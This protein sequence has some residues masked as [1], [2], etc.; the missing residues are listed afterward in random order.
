MR[1][2]RVVNLATRRFLGRR[3]AARSTRARASR[4]RILRLGASSRLCRSRYSRSW[5][6]RVPARAR[7]CSCSRARRASRPRERQRSRRAA[8]APELVHHVHGKSRVRVARTWREGAIHH[9]VE[10]NVEVVIES[11]MA[12]AYKTSS[13]EGM[14]ATDTTKNQCYV[15]ARRLRERCGRKCTPSRSPA[16]SSTSTPSSPPCTS[17]SSSNRGDASRS[18]AD[19][20]TTGSPPSTSAFSRSPPRSTRRDAP[21][22]SSGRTRRAA[23]QN[24]A[25]RVRGISQRRTHGVA[26]HAGSNP[27]DGVGRRVV[28]RARREPRRDR[29]RRAVT[30]NVARA[31]TELFYGPPRGAC[32][33]PACN[34]RCIRWERRWWNA[35]RRCDR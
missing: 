23:A 31:L 19:R 28:V 1:R 35:R 21:E 27:G 32:I 10:W 24:H 18:W 22:M 12:H 17:A 13:N 34:T 7:E 15:V 9:F 29:F 8:M 16:S 5:S 11:D 4:V 33:R 14:T 20:T 6:S 30:R 2:R 26:R 25:E 3:D